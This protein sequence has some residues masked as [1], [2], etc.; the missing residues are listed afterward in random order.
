MRT[1]AVVTGSRSDYSLLRPVM[2]EIERHKDLKL[3]PLMLGMHFSPEHGGTYKQ[4]KADFPTALEIGV[5]QYTRTPTEMMLAES[6]YQMNMACLFKN[7]PVDIVVVLGD[8][9]EA[10]AA[11]SAAAIS[12]IP[13]AH[14]HG[15]DVSGCIDNKLRHAITQLADWHFTATKRSTERVNELTGHSPNVWC[16]GSPAVDAALGVKKGWAFGSVFTSVVVNDKEVQEPYAILVLHP[17]PQNP[18]LPAVITEALKPCGLDYVWVG[19]NNDAGYKSLLCHAGLPSVPHEVYIN[20]LRHCQLLIGNS[21]SAFIE[22]SALGIPAVNIGDRQNGR[23]NA[24]NVFNCKAD[25]DSI[26]KAIQKALKWKRVKSDLY[27]DGKA[28]KRIVEVLRKQ[29]I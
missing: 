7:Y 20:T 18:V 23:E 28:S 26:C 14:I 6:D 5:G 17:D 16:V 11:A 2:K 24:G 12:K 29:A 22:C 13:L 8:R 27:G 4:V 19:P 9:I 25:C 1:V 10:F 3:V 21:S 15:G